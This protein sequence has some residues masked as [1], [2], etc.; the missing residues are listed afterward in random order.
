[1]TYKPEPG[2]LVAISRN[3]NHSA[4][5]PWQIRYFDGH[6]LDTIAGYVKTLT[7]GWARPHTDI[8]HGIHRGFLVGEIQA[9]HDEHA[10]TVWCDRLEWNRDTHR[11]EFLT[12][13]DHDITF[14]HYAAFTDEGRA[15]GVDTRRRVV[16]STEPC[17]RCAPWSTAAE[18]WAASW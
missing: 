5:A 18:E 9:M 8:R 17:P 1:M 15:Y 6:P 12:T 14:L 10:P 2:D 11:F 13:P 7:L 3:L 16:A 4:H